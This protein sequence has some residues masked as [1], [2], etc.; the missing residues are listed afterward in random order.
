MEPGI[1]ERNRANRVGQCVS[2]D[3]HKNGG[4][5]SAG[6]ETFQEL[7]VT[8]FFIGVLQGF[9]SV[10]LKNRRERKP[11]NEQEIKSFEQTKSLSYI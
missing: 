10:V 4:I 1:D 8:P 5:F 3:K 9:F 11:Q 6:A 7:T 2:G